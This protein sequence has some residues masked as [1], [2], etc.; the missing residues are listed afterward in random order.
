MGCD[1]YLRSSFCCGAQLHLEWNSRYTT[2]TTADELGFLWEGSSHMMTLEYIGL[3]FMCVLLILLSTLV[4]NVPVVLMVAPSIKGPMGWILL[5]WA[6]TVGG[7]FTIISSAANII[8]DEKA[9][10]MN[11]RIR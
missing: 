3:F 1:Y 6:I 9:G 2:C 7:N 4:S 11:N 10:S 8:V 5:S